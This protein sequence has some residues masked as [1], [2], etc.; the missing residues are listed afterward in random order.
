M[1]SITEEQA[2]DD[3]SKMFFDEWPHQVFWDDVRDQRDTSETP[4]ASFVIRHATGDQDTLG[5]RGA[6]SFLREGTIT[7]AIHTPTGNGLSES[8][9]LG[10]VARNIYE[11]N[12]SPN[13][14]WF[15]KVRIQEV[16]RR[17][18]FF[19]RNMLVDFQYYE[20]K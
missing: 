12:S 15:R 16:G 3:M 2:V 11:G 18:S 20:V 4:W 19:Q 9:A 7:V 1:S 5:G 13:G 6:R 8:I 10:T 17:G 14:V